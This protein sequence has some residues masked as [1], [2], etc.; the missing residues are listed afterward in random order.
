M[1][2][3]T[4]EKVKDAITLKGW[5]PFEK[6]WLVVSILTIAIISFINQ[7]TPIGFISAISGIICVVLAAKGKIA[8]FYV[9]IIQAGTYAYI[10]HGYG[11]YGEAILN[12]FFY[13]PTQFIGLF[14]WYRHRKIKNMAVNNEDVFAKRL[15]KKQWYILT[16]I[17]LAAIG[18]FMFILFEINATVPGI[19]SAAVILSV[20]AQ[21]L[22][23][24][25]YTEQWLFWIV[26]NI[27]TITVWLIALIQTGGNNWALLA[28]WVAFLINSTYGY[29][30]WRKI[31]KPKTGNTPV[32]EAIV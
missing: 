2:L 11:L 29:V 30:N 8:T 3:M 13:L 25:R 7:E 32:Q 31:S 17:T 9:G 1:T 14:L 21:I 16:P 6:I 18:I 12:A 22:L 19:D 26:V 23:L 28:M 15:S 27:L 24:L 5:K 20:I 10:A 4:L